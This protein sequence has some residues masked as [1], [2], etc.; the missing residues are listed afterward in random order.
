MAGQTRGLS[1]DFSTRLIH[2]EWSI[3]PDGSDSGAGSTAS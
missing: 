3:R 1:F 2:L